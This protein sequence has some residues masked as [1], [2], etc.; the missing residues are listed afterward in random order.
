MSLTAAERARRLE[1]L[2]NAFVTIEDG[3]ARVDGKL[4]GLP[5]A[6]KDI[7][8]TPSRR[9]TGGLATATDLGIEGE[10]DLLARLDDAGG[11]R[12]GF[13]GLPELAYEPSGYN[14]A[15]GRVRNPWNLD[16]VAGGS[17]SG[18]A[19]AV[20]TGSAVIALGSDT[21]GSLRIPAH[22]CGIAAWK[23][24]YGIVPRAGTMPLAPSLDTVGLLARSACDMRDVVD[25]L[26]EDH[27]S[28]ADGPIAR[29]GAGRL[30]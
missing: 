2:L 19:A 24:T 10:T 20:A 30:L 21:A 5:Y 22:C 13:T 26:I 9:P 11:R 15:R 17:S 25:L 7:F 6:A 12:V 23:P 14:H 18:S 8:R 3:V 28:R 29:G 27:Q 16:F 4:G 1:P